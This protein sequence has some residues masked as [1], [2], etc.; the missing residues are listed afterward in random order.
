MLGLPTLYM[1]TLGEFRSVY[2]GTLVT[3]F[4]TARLQNLLAYLLI[5]HASELST[6]YL[7]FLLLPDFPSKRLPKTPKTIPAPK[8]PTADEYLHVET[9]TVHRQIDSTY[10][11]DNTGFAPG[12]MGLASVASTTLLTFSS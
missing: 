4:I 11:L 1:Q 8:F 12:R 5:Y 6:K 7:A 3:T 9:E 10:S 2:D